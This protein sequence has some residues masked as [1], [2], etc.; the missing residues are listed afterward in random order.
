MSEQEAIKYINALYAVGGQ[1]DFFIEE[2]AEALGMAVDALE[3]QSMVN[4]F[5]NEAEK[6]KLALFSV[7]RNNTMPMA[8]ANGWDFDTINV[9]AVKTMEQIIEQCRF[10][11]LKDFYEDALAK[12]GGKA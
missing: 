4:E 9:L 7:I 10:H 12:M 5:L 6:Y 8:E 3:K 1:K 11:A 2:F